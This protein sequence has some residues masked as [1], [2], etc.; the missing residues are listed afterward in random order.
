MTV[1]Y[2]PERLISTLFKCDGSVLPKVFWRALIAAIIGLSIQLL[3]FFSCNPSS[4][5]DGATTSTWSQDVLQCS[6]KAPYISNYLG[7]NIDMVRA[8]VA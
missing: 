8:C 3:F 1:S 4:P 7:P 6:T 2:E 5:I